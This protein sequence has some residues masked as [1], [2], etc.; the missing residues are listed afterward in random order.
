MAA[1]YFDTTTTLHVLGLF[2][3]RWTENLFLSCLAL[4]NI[5]L[6]SWR[7][8]TI[9]QF[10][11]SIIC[12]FFPSLCVVLGTELI[13]ARYRL[14]ITWAGY[15]SVTVFPGSIMWLNHVWSCVTQLYG[16]SQATVITTDNHCSPWWEMNPQNSAYTTCSTDLFDLVLVLNTVQLMFLV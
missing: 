3:G 15:Q 10:H 8:D 12:T 5:C 14:D 11:P 2:W 9:S 4:L 13:P 6:P 7:L 16:A 1:R